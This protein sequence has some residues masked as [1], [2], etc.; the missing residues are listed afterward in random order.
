MKTVQFLAGLSLAIPTLAASSPPPQFPE[1]LGIV[2]STPNQCAPGQSLELTFLP[3]ALR[4]N[5][6]SMFFGTEGHGRTN[7]FAVC[8]FTTEFT[9]WWYKY[10]F[11]I[12]GVKYSGRFN[13]TDSVQLHELH[14]SAIFRY[15]ILKVNK[16]NVPPEIW[17]LSMSTMSHTDLP[18]YY[19]IDHTA[20]TTIGGDGSFNDDF[21][22][23]SNT[24]QVEWS[25]CMDGG[26]GEGGSKTKIAFQI[27]GE[28]TDKTGKGTGQFVNG[29]TLEFPLVW[30]ECYP[31]RAVKNAWGETRIDDWSTCTYNDKNQTSRAITRALRHGPG[32]LL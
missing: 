31:D 3:D 18:T 11:G 10:R 26:E 16:G 20:Q 5:L 32:P 19:K 7:E 9:S 4:L 12:Q 27:T 25:P 21:E 23:S 6:P 30:E 2:T 22:V 13:A 17:N 29:L 24:S 1:V 8:E 15:E 14:S 28:T